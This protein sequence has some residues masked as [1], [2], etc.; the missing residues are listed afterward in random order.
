MASQINSARDSTGLAETTT[1]LPQVSCLMPTYNRARFVR[2]AIHYFQRQDYQNKELIVLD[3]GSESVAHLMP[4][5]PQI[6]YFRSERRAT[7]S[8]KLNLGCQLAQGEIFLNWDD[9]DWMADWRI[10]YQVE[11]LLR[12][13]TDI[14]GL[15]HGFY[16][17]P[18]TNRAWRFV[19]PPGLRLWLQGGTFCYWK[20]FW[21]EH[22]YPNIAT[23]G[24]DTQFLWNSRSRTITVLPDSTFYVTIVHQNNTCPKQTF[25]HWYQPQP[26]EQV[27]RLLGDAVKFYDSL[28]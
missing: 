16:Y 8:E 24:A 25:A 27:R 22:P 7:I 14:C 26:V 17:Q 1:S 10:K 13:Q 9:D 6:R 19:Y 23:G 3:D 12:E 28:Y 2:Q 15:S 11:T 4:E 20:S 5:D 21:R 18:E